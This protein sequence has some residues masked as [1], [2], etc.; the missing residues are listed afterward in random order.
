MLSFAN[1]IDEQMLERLNHKLDKAFPC[2]NDSAEK[3]RQAL[4]DALIHAKQVNDGFLYYPAS[5]AVP[6]QPEYEFLPRF[7]DSPNLRGI[8]LNDLHFSKEH[9]EKWVNTFE[10][11]KYEVSE[12]DQKQQSF[13][14]AGGKNAH[15]PARVKLLAGDA[16]NLD[17]RIAFPE[18][19]LT[20]DYL[21]FQTPGD[22]FGE[23]SADPA[24]YAHQL[25]ML[26]LGGILEVNRNARRPYRFFGSEDSHLFG[27]ELAGYEVDD[28]P[29][30]KG[31][32]PAWPLYL[33][34]AEVEPQKLQDLINLDFRLHVYLETQ[35]LRSFA[36]EH[37]DPTRGYSE[38]MESDLYENSCEWRADFTTETCTGLR[39]LSLLL[40]GDSQTR[41]V[42]RAKECI[43]RALLV[44]NGNIPTALKQWYETGDFRTL[45]TD[46]QA[47][48]D[49]LRTILLAMLEEETPNKTLARQNVDYGVISF[50]PAAPHLELKHIDSIWN[51]IEPRVDLRKRFAVEDRES[52]LHK[53]GKSESQPATFNILGFQAK[54][55]LVFLEVERCS[56][57]LAWQEMLDWIR[58]GR[59]SL[60]FEDVWS[61]DLLEVELQLD[62]FQLRAITSLAID[63]KFEFGLNLSLE[64]G[65]GVGTLSYN[66]KGKLIDLV[67]RLESRMDLNPGFKEEL[68]LELIRACGVLEADAID[69]SIEHQERIIASDIPDEIRW[70]LMSMI[71]GKVHQAARYTQSKDP[72]KRLREYS[73]ED[74]C[75]ML[76]H[77]RDRH[78]YS[79]LYLLSNESASVGE[80]A[81]LE[82]KRVIALALCFGLYRSRGEGVFRF[83]SLASTT[84]RC[85]SQFEAVPPE[86]VKRVRDGDVIARINLA[87][88]ST[89]L[90]ACIF[91]SQELLSAKDWMQ[92]LANEFQRSLQ[93]YKTS[94]VVLWEPSALKDLEHS[95]GFNVEVSVSSNTSR[96]I[97][98]S[99]PKELLALDSRMPIWYFLEAFGIDPGLAE[100][101]D[102]GHGLGKVSIGTNEING[103]S[104]DALKRAIMDSAQ[105]IFMPSRGRD[106]KIS[107]NFLKALRTRDIDCLEYLYL[108][109][110]DR[111][112]AALVW[113]LPN[114][115]P[116]VHNLIYRSQEPLF[117][118]GLYSLGK[119]PLS[120]KEDDS[121]LLYRRIVSF[122]EDGSLHRIK[123]A[124]REGSWETVCNQVRVKDEGP[125]YGLVFPNS[126]SAWSPE[127]I[128]FQ[129]Y[130]R[131]ML[132]QQQ[133]SD[134]WLHLGAT[135][136]NIDQVLSQFGC[137]VHSICPTVMQV[138]NV[139]AW[140][141][142]SGARG[143]STY[144]AGSELEIPKVDHVIYTVRDVRSFT[145]NSDKILSLFREQ[146]EELSDE[147]QVFVNGDWSHPEVAIIAKQ[148]E[149]TGWKRQIVSN[150]QTPLAP[151]DCFHLYQ[152]SKI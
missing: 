18:L 96:E 86:L 50:M 145:L 151:K 147:S 90:Y 80:A 87:W 109:T 82:H 41:A 5:G 138:K 53:L 9:F 150:M 122:L 107:D 7:E 118:K 104:G 152:R 76:E 101:T 12:V 44:S 112:P 95:R 54:I 98:Y 60:S 15:R 78:S 103:L 75:K 143:I 146:L 89:R 27:V 119:L 28:V 115:A 121:F 123:R 64:D 31:K 4:Y 97:A 20:L 106:G 61:Q 132:S 13:I 39:D 56:Q 59:E 11:F 93:M 67:A 65:V 1:E 45:T 57:R 100:I 114:E 14:I 19:N 66:T 23:L 85:C 29:K 3:Q 144:Y 21:Y 128:E 46:P 38:E 71:S 108:I 116:L 40:A 137:K 55:E 17:P 48:L 25:S 79:L 117:I 10:R 136:G 16:R 113:Q 22:H 69:I 6:F 68:D 32:S 35:L 92:D 24:F 142:L 49:S 37:S 30:L 140:S 74:L 91:D 62:L 34:T 26:K 131:H 77:A 126:N 105:I 43:Q 84:L 139:E 149:F 130:I 73:E 52:L 120:S 134:T 8:V 141:I 63:E 33:K 133:S 70:F 88:V 36:P 110:A 47:F 148:L 51:V 94:K 2:K 124:H 102:L 42:N 58:V 127:Q 135:N 83:Q 99:E 81:E 111:R 72:D 129:N 125:S